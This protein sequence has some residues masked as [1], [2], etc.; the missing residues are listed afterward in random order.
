LRLRAAEPAAIEALG[1]QADGENAGRPAN[2]WTNGNF[3]GSLYGNPGRLI[4][5]S[6]NAVGGRAPPKR[7]RINSG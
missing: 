4:C 7:E 1:A 3:M 2:A 6:S 5:V